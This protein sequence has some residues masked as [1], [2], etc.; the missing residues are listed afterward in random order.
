M[1]AK[2]PSI[3]LATMNAWGWTRISA[4]ADYVGRGLPLLLLDSRPEPEEGYPTDLDVAETQ[5]EALEAE[6]QA[7][8]TYNSYLI[9]A[10]AYVHQTLHARKHK[11][12][13]DSVAL[14]GAPKQQTEI[15]EVSYY[16]IVDLV[17]RCTFD[18]NIC[19]CSPALCHGVSIPVYPCR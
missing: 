15:F 19:I 16:S 18:R 17:I 8:G 3:G 6:L 1:A 9:S 10:L 11:L 13:R 4:Y 12:R 7:K 2:L 5:I 14:S